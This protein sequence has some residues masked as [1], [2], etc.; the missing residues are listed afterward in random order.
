MEAERPAYD[1]KAHQFVS[2]AVL[3]IGKNTAFKFSRFLIIHGGVPFLLAYTVFMIS[4]MI[5]IMHLENMLGQFC[6]LGNLGIFDT[7][8][9]FRGLGYT[10]TYYF[11]IVL[12]ILVTESSYEAL[13]LVNV[14]RDPLPWYSC[15][16]PWVSDA[17][18]CYV[19]SKDKELCSA[20]QNQL[21]QKYV[22]QG[23]QQG[24]PV[25]D[26]T[27]T[28]FVIKDLYD[29]ASVE[30]CVNGSVSSVHLYVLRHA[31][32]MDAS[33]RDVDIFNSNLALTTAVMWLIVFLISRDGISKAKHAMYIIGAIQLAAMSMMLVRLYT[34]W[35]G[36]LA[37]RLLFGKKIKALVNPT[38]WRD[39]L[40]LSV[41]NIGI[42]GG[43]FLN[44]VRYNAFRND[45]RPDIVAVFLMEI[46]YNI[47]CG[48]IVYMHVGYLALARGVDIDSVV[49]RYTDIQHDIMTEALSV[50]DPSGLWCAIYSIWVLSNAL[51]FMLLGPEVIL[52]ALFFDFPDMT[53]IRTE[54]SFFACCGFY[55]M[56]LL[57]STEWGSCI[58]P[59]MCHELEV[60]AAIMMIVEIYIFVRVYGMPH[61]M[62]D[63]HTILGEFPS[64]E[65]R[66]SWAA[67][68][69][70]LLSILI[71]LEI[72]LPEKF[73]FDGKPYSYPYRLTSCWLL[74]F[75]FSFTFVYALVL[76]HRFYFVWEEVSRPMKS[77][78]PDNR[79]DCM[80]RQRLLGEFGIKLRLATEVSTSATHSK[81][82]MA[83]DNT[84]ESTDARVELMLTSERSV[85]FAPDL[86]TGAGRLTPAK[87]HE[88][89][90]RKFGID[91]ASN[92]E[93]PKYLPSEDLVKEVLAAEY[94]TEKEE[95]PYGKSN[96]SVVGKIKKTEQADRTNK[97]KPSEEQKRKPQGEPQLEPEVKRNVVAE[98]QEERDTE[99]RRQ[100][101]KK[102]AHR[103][104]RKGKAL[105]VLETEATC[106]AGEV[107]QM[108]EDDIEDANEDKDLIS[109]TEAASTK[110]SDQKSLASFA[111]SSDQAAENCTQKQTE[112]SKKKGP[113][114][115]RGVHK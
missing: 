27:D 82:S 92:P 105:T 75:G 7:V 52:D 42:Y 39:A 19:Q 31:R 12:V 49:D 1:S 72:A 70:L 87:F 55:I 22:D 2:I 46:S 37:L 65:I 85:T 100:D 9:V 74:T 113:K 71:C 64:F 73:L 79:E 97:R 95:P 101:K 60:M 106:Q 51:G 66:I 35:S 77:W 104:P 38:M 26:G 110:H 99:G 90:A 84:A 98:D 43:S 111:K 58:L 40:K 86:P 57:L 41:S 10:I 23:Y 16:E 62:V 28:A 107:L 81:L 108:D 63:Y 109:R 50:G 112:R 36:R 88:D 32:Y 115:G 5:P 29:N 20:L 47:I 96:T 67:V 103:K 25:T 53:S 54:C 8:P 24:I 18:A 91:L 45:F 69:P 76:L 94:E 21:L 48:F 80:E 11:T 15:I 59:L 14:F 89:M 102:I 34:L 93:R 3:L 83:G 56:G 13:F 33:M 68:M 30:P 44:V 114:Q 17:D 78:K 4:V 61:L 6:G